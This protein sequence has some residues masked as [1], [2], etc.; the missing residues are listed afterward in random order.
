MW[1]VCYAI[2]SRKHS[3]RTML[4][5]L[6]TVILIV[7][8]L[9]VTIITTLGILVVIAL[10]A[11]LRIPAI[12]SLSSLL[13]V[14]VLVPRLIVPPSIL[15]ELLARLERLGS[16]LERTCARAERGLLRVVI[17]IHLLGLPR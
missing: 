4:R 12:S 7:T 3:S 2:A 9:V 17:Q 5:E 14:V 13:V 8:T 11:V 1:K 15:L 10:L 6:P 16:G